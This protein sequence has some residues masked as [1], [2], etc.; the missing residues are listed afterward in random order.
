MH[1]SF[2]KRQEIGSSRETFSKL[3][4]IYNIAGGSY[5]LHVAFYDLKVT[6]SLG[7][8]LPI[9]SEFIRHRHPFRGK[10]QVK[11]RCKDRKTVHGCGRYEHKLVNTD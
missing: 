8:L 11:Q 9:D 3:L 10:N 5:F 1:T 6:T 7:Y 2:V 4:I